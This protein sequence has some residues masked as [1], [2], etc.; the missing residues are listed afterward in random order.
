MISSLP[1]SLG[2]TASHLRP[3]DRARQSRSPRFK[4]TVRLPWIDVDA[5]VRDRARI[6]DL[7]ADN[8]GKDECLAMV[9]HELRNSLAPMSSAADV[10]NMPGVSSSTSEQAKGI[11]TR[12]LQNMTRL[13]NDLLDG[14]RI[15]Q[16]KMDLRVAPTDLTALLQHA[17][18][19]VAPQTDQRDQHVAVSFPK[20]P[21]QVLGDATRLEQAFGN[22]LNNAS[23]FT[24]RGGRIWLSAELGEAPDGSR[25]AVVHIRDEG[26]GITAEMLPHVFDLFRQAGHSPH[27]ASGLGVGLALVRRIVELHGGRVTLQSAG[28]DKGS[29]F[30]VALPLLEDAPTS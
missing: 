23:K 19:A 26:I 10:L 11:I 4:S 24:R 21:W 8:Q 20:A 17:I 14:A 25:E 7:L 16:G 2:D 1:G 13:V 29:E 18:E 9:A 22:L 6:A 28:I 3:A 15:T 27:H 12:Q 30:I 5:P